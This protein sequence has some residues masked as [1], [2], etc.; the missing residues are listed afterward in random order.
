ME[1]IVSYRI[2]RIPVIVDL[3]TPSSSGK[4]R[5]RDRQTAYASCR[6]CTSSQLQTS[7]FV[8]LGPDCLGFYT[9]A[10]LAPICLVP[11]FTTWTNICSLHWILDSMTEDLQPAIAHQWEPPQP[12]H[13]QST[14]DR[15]KANVLNFR[16]DH[17]MIGESSCEETWL[18]IK[19]RVDAFDKYRSQKGYHVRLICCLLYRSLTNK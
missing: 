19:G 9:Y 2:S 6:Q 11:C 4:W 15:S 10:F 5:H 17:C 1:V 12:L 13:S 8:P 3:W 16:F 14:M 7:T 18:S